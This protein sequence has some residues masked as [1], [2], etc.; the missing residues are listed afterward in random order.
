[1]ARCPHCAEFLGTILPLKQQLGPALELHLGYVGT[2][3]ES[4]EADFAHG[5][6]EV[7]AA[8]IQVCVGQNAGDTEWIDFLACL[9]EGDAWQTLPKGWTT[10]ARRAGVDIEEVT[11]CVDDGEGRETLGQAIAAAAASGIDAAP[12]AILDGRL[13]LGD[14]GREGFLAQFCHVAGAPE[15][16]PAL[17]DEV[18]AP[19]AVEAVLLVDSRC[20]DPRLCDVSRELGFLA[21][22]IPTLEVAELDFTTVEGRRAYD[23]FVDAGG[24]RHLPLLVFG[25]ALEEYPT[26]MEQMQEHLLALGG[27]YLMPL[28][29]G[30]DPLAE[31]CDNGADDDGDGAVDCDDDGCSAALACREERKGRLDLFMMSQCPFSTELV[32]P[33]RHFLEHF[34]N[35]AKTVDLRLQF[36]GHVT[37]EGLDSMHGPDEVAEDLRMVCAQ[38]LYR[39]RFKYLEYVACRAEEFRSTDWE[40]CVPKGMSVGKLRKCAEGDEGRELLAESFELADALGIRGSPTWIVNDRYEVD[41]RSAAEL[42]QQF[43]FHNQRKACKEE[44]PPEPESAK[45][46]TEKCE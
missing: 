33:L 25:S 14:R 46:T 1:M 17:C 7:A 21:V 29:Q 27:G 45:A 20:D 26:V 22:L 43:C 3:D 13:Y 5:D 8:E 19:P 4:G 44:M 34:G 6:A 36:I 16:R 32:A 15:T 11:T 30:W 24:P 41:A 37:D 10:C 23:E 39:S 18:A 38:Q 40:K 42:K 28:G 35:D 9:Y 31:I 12:T 2:V